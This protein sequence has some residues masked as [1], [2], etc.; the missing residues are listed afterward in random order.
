LWLWFLACRFE[1]AFRWLR[2]PPAVDEGLP[3]D[4]R[5]AWR[6]AAT[7][8]AIPAWDIPRLLAVDDHLQMAPAGHPARGSLLFLKAWGRVFGDRD[9]LRRLLPEV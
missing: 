8:I 1:E 7:W 2:L 5:L 3:L 4:A 6:T 9:G